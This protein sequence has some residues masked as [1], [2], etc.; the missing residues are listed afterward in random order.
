M[1][2]FEIVEYSPLYQEHAKDLLLTLQL[3]LESL[4]GCAPKPTFRDELTCYDKAFVWQL[5]QSWPGAPADYCLRAHGAVGKVTSAK[6]GGRLRVEVE[7]SVNGRLFAVQA[8]PALREVTLG[9]EFADK[10]DGP[11][12]YL[13]YASQGERIF[14]IAKRYHARARDLV[15]ANH[16]EPEPGGAVQEMTTEKTCLLIPAAL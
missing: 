12:L 8:S 6:A 10:A 15:A 14:D 5:P 16:L 11:A 13:Y 9:E 4:G 1:E 3:H 2:Q 7:V